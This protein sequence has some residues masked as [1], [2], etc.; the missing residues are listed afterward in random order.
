MV[1]LDLPCLD[2]NGDYPGDDE[3]PPTDTAL[4]FPSGLLAWGGSLRPGRLIEAYRR[5]IFPW[6]SEGEPVLWWTPSPRCVLY[7][8]D[9][10]VSKRTR[11]K[12]RQRRFTLTADT[13]F[14]EVI[15]GCAA[16]RPD[17]PST[18]ITAEMLEAYRALHEMGVAHSVEAWLDGRLVGGIYGL[19]IGRMF[20]GESMFSLEADASKVALITLCRQLDEW[21]FGPLD[22]QV[23]NPHLKSMGAVEIEREAFEAQLGEFTAMPGPDPGIGDSWRNAFRGEWDW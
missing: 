7:P 19:S 20:F 9:V 22:C 12:L 14:A 1:L 17:R 18:W 8:A 16:P 11:Q 23:G 13:A 21:G 2:A 4:D 15:D 3:F 5:G 10:Y 6:Y